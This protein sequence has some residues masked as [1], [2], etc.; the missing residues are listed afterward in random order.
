MSIDLI[1]YLVGYVLLFRPTWRFMM[2]H[3]GEKKYDEIEWVDVIFC[4]A[5]T[6][7][8]A[9]GWPLYIVPAIVWRFIGW[10][11]YDAKQFARVLGGRTRDMKIKDK[12][13]ELNRREA[14]LRQAED[15]LKLERFPL[16]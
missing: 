11:G 13:R 1:I 5:F 2:L 4:S 6:L 15:D 16:G 12:E 14:E 3:V 7:V 9:A 10:R 8:L